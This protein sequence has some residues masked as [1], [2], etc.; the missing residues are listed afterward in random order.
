MSQHGMGPHTAGL[1]EV[2]GGRLEEEMAQLRQRRATAGFV[3]DLGD[4]TIRGVEPRESCTGQ[5]LGSTCAQTGERAGAA[6]M[7]VRFT[8]APYLRE[9]GAMRCPRAAR[10]I[11]TRMRPLVRPALQCVALYAAQFWEI[12]HARPRRRGE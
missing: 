6:F 9:P 12:A 8:R 7:L 4:V 2:P 5:G 3:S 10:H 11:R 1:L